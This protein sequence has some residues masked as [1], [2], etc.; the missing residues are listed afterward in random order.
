MVEALVSAWHNSFRLLLRPFT[1]RRWITLSAVC[2]LL[3]GGTWSAA[4]QWAFGALPEDLHAAQPLVQLRQAI[5]QSPT[6]VVLAVLVTLSL[7]LLHIYLR[8]VFR[9]V[10][11]EAVIRGEVEVGA[12]WKA[13]RPLGHSYFRWTLGVLS[14]I[15]MLIGGITLAS[16]RYIHLV[17][18]EGHPGWIAPLLLVVELVAI[19]II[20]LAIAVFITLTDDLVTPVMYA[21]G[22]SPL[23]A[24]KT[25]GKLWRAEPGTFL[26]YIVL[27]FT[28]SLGISAAVLFVLFPLLAALSA[29]ALL[30]ATLITFSLHQLGLIWTW[31]P[32]TVTLGLL[33]LGTLT[34]LVFALL[35]VAGMPGQVY[36]Q[37]LGVR[38]VASRVSSLDD[39]CHPPGA[40]VP[41]TA[42]LPFDQ[43][44]NSLGAA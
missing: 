5:G 41:E 17:R 38:F 16:F 1:S 36:M 23:A 32:L 26:F 22:G 28:L 40:R 33:A 29:G 21:E 11:V 12:R 31:N 14:A 30:A 34:L 3:G 37:N 39:L 42:V 7:I 4:F 44:E 19:V 15:L 18:Q 20:G 6:L 43:G 25:V 13:L 27:R 2:L 24:W 10:L 9:F 8:S 35:S